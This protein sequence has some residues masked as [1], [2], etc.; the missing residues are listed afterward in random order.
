MR[1]LG[2]E[3]EMSA[4]EP[5]CIA[6]VSALP[7]FSQNS[8]E[9]RTAIVFAIVRD[10]QHDLPFEHTLPNEPAADA[11]DVLVAVHELQLTAQEP[12][13]RRTRHDGGSLGKG[14]IL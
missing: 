3:Y 6:F 2:G 1:I 10:H 11:G 7:P 13:G 14:T 8:K 4:V 5:A 9:I 12:R